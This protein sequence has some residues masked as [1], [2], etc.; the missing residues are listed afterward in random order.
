MATKI[1]CTS[2]AMVPPDPLS[3]SP[4]TS[5]VVKSMENME[6]APDD[7]EPVAAGEYNNPQII[8]TA[9]VEEQ[10]INYLSECR[11]VYVLSDNLE[12]LIIQ[13]L[14]GAGLMEFYC[15]N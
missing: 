5:S 1:V 10:Y 4:S 2:T 12:Y 7:L 9:Q 8:Y 3:P 14:F 6:E 11:S 13:Y 15:T